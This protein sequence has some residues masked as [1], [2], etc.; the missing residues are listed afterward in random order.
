MDRQTGARC[1]NGLRGQQGP[2]EVGSRD[3]RRGAAGSSSQSKRAKAVRA[4]AS[5]EKGQARRQKES[6][7][8]GA[9]AREKSGEETCEAV[10]AAAS[11]RH[12][13]AILVPFHTSA[14]AAPKPR[15]L[16][17]AVQC[18][19]SRTPFRRP[20]KKKGESLRFVVAVLVRIGLG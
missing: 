19:F 13:C 20:A 10:T 14:V 6:E 4:L 9:E 2:G 12:A 8:S 1:R 17:S 11:S 16:K 15:W 5:P 7:S 3:S 18:G